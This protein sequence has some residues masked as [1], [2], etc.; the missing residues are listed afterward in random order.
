MGTTVTPQRIREVAYDLTIPTDAD[1]AVE[2]LIAK[3]W[4]RV[5]VAFPTVEDRIASG[6]L[7]ADVV[8]GVV[9]DMVI[10]VLRNPDAR[11]SE[12]VDDYRYSI[13][14]ALASGRLYIDDDERALLTPPGRRSSVGS[15][16]LGVPSWRVP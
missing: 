11:T 2:R 12:G 13:D 14:K 5:K 1:P 6:A 9:E 4:Q 3:A 16:R 8:D 7:D 15:I 10:R